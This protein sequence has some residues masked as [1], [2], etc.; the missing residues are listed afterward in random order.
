MTTEAVVTRIINPEMAE[1]VVTRGTACG[2]SCGSCE[3]CVFENEIKTECMLVSAL[4]FFAGIAYMVYRG[5]RQKEE[6][7]IKFSIISLLDD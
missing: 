2:G 3:A 4:A 1:V 5:R 7:Q 6:E